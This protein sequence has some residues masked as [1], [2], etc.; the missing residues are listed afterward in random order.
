MSVSLIVFAALVAFIPCTKAEHIA[1]DPD[2][3]DDAIVVMGQSRSTPSSTAFV[4]IIDVES[5]SRRGMELADLLQ[6]AVGTSVREM[7]GRGNTATVAL[8]GSS[9]AQVK[10]FLDGVPLSNA[11]SFAVNVAEI[12]P[13]A[14]AKIEIYRGSAPV[15]F[16]GDAI[17]GVVNIITKAAALKNERIATGRLQYGSF[18]TMQGSVAGAEPL[19]SVVVSVI[20]SGLN[21]DG[22]F[23]YSNDNGT[24][25]TTDD[26]TEEKRRNNDILRG[27]LIVQAQTPLS[28]RFRL[29]I[30]DLLLA[31]RQ[32]LAGIGN[33]QTRAAEA[34]TLGNTLQTDVEGADFGLDGSRAVLTTYYG[35][36][37]ASFHDPQQELGLSGNASFSRTFSQLGQRGRLVLP[38]LSFGTLSVS[39]EGRIETVGYSETMLENVTHST[40]QKHE[41]NTIGVG[42]QH[43]LPFFSGK[44]LWQSGM[45][46]DLLR[47]NGQQNR[48]LF[49]PTMGLRQRLSQQ[50]TLR[51]NIGFYHR[52]PN[53]MELY[54]YQGFVKGNPDL[55][56]ERSLNSDLGVAL[57]LQSE[58]LL[59]RVDLETAVFSRRSWDL[60]QYVQ[61]SQR[62]VRPENIARSDVYGVEHSTT[63]EL[64]SFLRYTA[65]HTFIIA[66]NKSNLSWQR[67]RAIPMLPRHEAFQRLAV[68][69]AGIEAYYDLNV[70]SQA[71]RDAANLIPIPKRTLHGTGLTSAL[72]WGKGW[73]LSA[74]VQNFTDVRTALV[75]TSAVDGPQRGAIADFAGYPLPGRSFFVTLAYKGG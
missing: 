42:I 33:I 58:K 51:S 18:H 21:T 15:A 28:E 57:H 24:P 2:P 8:R 30:A 22:D 14:I 37:R 43:E 29:R 44:T 52:A 39:T 12:P 31:K 49:A 66:K 48:W 50:L 38:S 73:S 64:W 61:N 36:N 68:F 10:I 32:G 59:R 74:E 4:A 7:G 67:G 41:R 11:G 63:A 45:R 47:D 25:F 70:F 55:R 19:G 16:G 6:N 69:V 60:I 1:E 26:D 5:Q 23:S 56:K 13:E 3:S 54:D 62:T 72:P 46:I 27:G 65:N 35:N 20:G 71:Y 9:S 34:E 75:T 17:G 53:F 40:A